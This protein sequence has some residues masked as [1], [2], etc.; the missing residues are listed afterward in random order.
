MPG[1]NELLV[2]LRLVPLPVYPLTNQLYL[3]PATRPVAFVGLVVPLIL[4]YQPVLA[5]VG[6]AQSLTP[7]CA[8]ISQTK[9]DVLSLLAPFVQLSFTEAFAA[10]GQLV[11][12]CSAVG[13]FG[14]GVTQTPVVVLQ[15]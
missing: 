2:N 13:A 3:C 7:V 11:G 4:V 9:A 10:T 12:V 8:V 15:T 14:V 6:I 5:V 1:P